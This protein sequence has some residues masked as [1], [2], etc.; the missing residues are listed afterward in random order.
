MTRSQLF[1]SLEN[2]FSRFPLFVVCGRRVSTVAA[3]PCVPL[4]PLSCLSIAAGST[5]CGCGCIYV[6]YFI[7]V[8]KNSACVWRRPLLSLVYC[9][10]GGATSGREDS[11]RF[12]QSPEVRQRRANTRVDYGGALRKQLVKAQ[13]SRLSHSARRRCS[14]LKK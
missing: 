7:L 3:A 4:H 8:N 9:G 11:G 1:F 6:F 2:F 10:G 14:A 5:L 12:R 13:N